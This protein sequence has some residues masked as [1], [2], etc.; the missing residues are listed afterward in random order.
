[1]IDFGYC[2]GFIEMSEFS[3]CPRFAFSIMGTGATIELQPTN[4]RILAPTTPIEAIDDVLASFLNL[5]R[6]FR[7][8][9]TIQQKPYMRYTWGSHFRLIQKFVESIKNNVEVP[10]DVNEGILSIK[11][12]AA[13]DKSIK[14]GEKITL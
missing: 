6:I 11:L 12:S 14:L 3:A 10:A 7:A 2:T 8:F 9:V 4:F 1:L 13:I 5:S